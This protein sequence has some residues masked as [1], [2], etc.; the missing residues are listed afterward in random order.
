MLT[1]QSKFRFSCHRNLACFTRCCR[2]INI[3]LTPYDVLRMK[4]NLGMSSGDFL[5]KYAVALI[6]ENTG[7]PVLLLKMDEQTGRCLFVTE[8]GCRIYADRPWSC[9][10]YPL[11]EDENG[12]YS[13][14]VD[15]SR[16]FGLDENQEWSVGEWLNE[17]GISAYNEI[18]ALFG[19]VGEQLKASGHQIRNP[20]IQEMYYTACYDLDKFKRFIFES[21][22]LKVFDIDRE[23][24]QK[25]KND[26]V[27]LLKFGFKWV[28]FGVADN[29][30]FKIRDEV[31]EA[32]RKAL[33]RLGKRA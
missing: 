18:E 9:R 14:V 12:N 8:K 3:F 26:E 13:L 16:C 22:F 4:N 25:I 30:S 21:S 15:N 32:K 19:K 20:R 17:Q 29:K 24:V 10:M 33:E 7:L 28:L 31:L 11:N 1:A 27:E 5:Q 6:A 2:E 23:T